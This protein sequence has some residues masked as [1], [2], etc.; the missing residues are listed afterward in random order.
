MP[1][2]RRRPS[3]LVRVLLP[4]LLLVLAT[5]A[6]LVAAG[7]EGGALVEED[8]WGPISTVRANRPRIRWRESC[9]A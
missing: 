8:R 5:T 3:L 2:D 7:A 4:L 9:G 6:A 1:W